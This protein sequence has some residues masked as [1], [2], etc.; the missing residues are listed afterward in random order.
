M[1]AELRAMPGLSGLRA[2]TDPD[3][4]VELPRN[5]DSTG[6]LLLDYSEQFCDLVYGGPGP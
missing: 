1:G 6:P 5:F 3:G 4:V 2:L